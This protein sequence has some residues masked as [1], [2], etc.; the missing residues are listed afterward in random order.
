[1]YPFKSILAQTKAIKQTLLV[2]VGSALFFSFVI[3][4][5]ILH[6]I[7]PKT[8][9]RD[10][11]AIVEGP[12]YLG[13][14]SNIGVL[15]WAATVA[16]C[17]LTYSFLSRITADS[18]FRALLF[19]AGLLSLFLLLDDFFLLHDDVLPN[20]LGLNGEIFT[21]VVYGLSILSFLFYFQKII[22]RSDFLL[23]FFALMFLGLSMTIDN[24]TALFPKLNVSGVYI[25]EDMFKFLGIITWFLYFSRLSL[26]ALLQYGYVSSA[27][28]KSD[29]GTGEGQWIGEGHYRIP[30]NRLGNQN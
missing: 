13:F 26:F 10:P 24:M 7:S 3:Y 22:L 6:D 30:D 21:L 18:P 19:F 15:F 20:Y 17:F 1:M 27:E 8:L 23:L 29:K 4:L 25:L 9:I 11:A 14:F 28:E 2:L 16:V 5:G 12:F